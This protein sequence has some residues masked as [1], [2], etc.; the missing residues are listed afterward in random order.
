VTV[1]GE[2]PTAK[3]GRRLWFTMYKNAVTELAE[4]L[5]EV[6]ADQ[7]SSSAE[8]IVSNYISES[9]RRKYRREVFGEELEA[10][11]GNV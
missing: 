2:T 10:V 7:G 11:F 9:E 8:I 3:M 4:E 1:D 5:E 6:A